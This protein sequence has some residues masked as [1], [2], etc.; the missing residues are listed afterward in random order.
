MPGALPRAA[1]ELLDGLNEP[2]RQAVSHVDGPLLVLAGPGSGKTR[3]ITNRAAFLVASGVPPRNILAITFTNKAADEMRR[4]IEALGAASGMWIYTF[5]ALCVRLLREFGSLVG[6]RPGFSIYDETDAGKLVQEAIE[7]SGTSPSLV[8]ADWARA[9]ISAAKARLQTPEAYASRDEGFEQ[10][11]VARVYAAYQRLLEER[12]AVDFD[13]LLMKVAQALHAHPDLTERLNVRFRYLLVDEYQDTNHAQYRIARALSQHHRNICVTGDPDQSIY[14]WRGADIHNILSFERDYPDAVTIRLEQ[15]YRS[16]GHILAIASR[17]IR[18]NRRRKH[19]ELWS[20]LGSGEKVTVWQFSEGGQEA[21][22]LARAIVAQRAA[23]RPYSDFAIFYRINA[24]SRGLEEA[25][26]HAEVPYRIARGVEFYNRKE[27]RDVL[28]YLRVLVNPA[29]EVAL[30]RII[31]TPAR[32]IGKTTLDRLTTLAAE[33]G[34]PLL[35]LLRTP[36][37]LDALG[38]AARKVRG[39][40]ELLDRL[41]PLTSASPDKAVSTVLTETGLEAMYAEEGEVQGESRIQNVQ[42]LVTAATRY[43]SELPEDERP[44]TLAGFLSHVSLVSDQDAVD[45][46]AGCVMLMTL[47]AAKGLEFPVVFLVGLE[48]GLLPHERALKVGRDD[49]LEEERRLCFVGLTRARERLYVSYCRERVIRGQV[50]PR[51]P[52]RFL[53]EFEAPGAIEH[54]D[55]RIRQVISPLYAN[56]PDIV[57]LVDDL[58]ADE[59]RSRL[60][61][62]SR[63][64]REVDE[65]ERIFENGVPTDPRSTGRKRR[66]EPAP[67]PPPD[68][69]FAGWREGS[70][71]KH[72]MYGV[73][74]LLWIRPAPGNTRAGVKFAGY[75]E[76]TLI[77]EFAPI[78]LLKR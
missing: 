73:G 10:A 45:P 17:L 26:R 14:A 33:R 38:T 37:A 31:N 74:T 68:S 54:V 61:G 60:G 66:P 56:R 11:A 69:P 16:T 2:Q 27:V 57:P 3:V 50:T 40:V 75:G 55:R 71:V 6:V 4:R 25:L 63:W 35:D 19:K 41:T 13:D 7:R 43:A 15:N 52:S 59:A 21:E 76:K 23:G 51:A 49:E 48:E 65:S 36:G 67:L 53:A 78:E 29:D 77:L 32:G 39:F 8:R 46:T 24:V 28:S 18:N 22:A 62:G 34:V 5:H 47:H 9:R 30:L 72:R 20:Q 42:E 44:P 70:L 12:N 58:S 1:Q 64:R